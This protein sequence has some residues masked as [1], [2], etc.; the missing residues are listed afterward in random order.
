MDK[1]ASQFTRS[2]R[3]KNRKDGPYRD[4]GKERERQNKIEAK[5]SK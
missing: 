1:D 4:G 5:F 3:G 2:T